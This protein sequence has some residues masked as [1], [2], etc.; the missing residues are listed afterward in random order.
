MNKW[1]PADIAFLEVIPVAEGAHACLDANN[2]T[3]DYFF[4]DF[5]DAWLSRTSSQVDLTKFHPKASAHLLPV[6]LEHTEFREFC[7]TPDRHNSTTVHFSSATFYQNR[8]G[9]RFRFRFVANRFLR[10][11]V[12]ILVNDLLMIGRNEMSPH[13][14]HA[15]LKTRSRQGPVRTA[16]PEGLYLTGVSYPYIDRPPQLPLCGQGEWEAIS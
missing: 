5:P 6:L 3:Y 11:M 15:L 13:Q 14:F 9:S 4:H 8:D 12:R 10:G 2:R 7:L 1:L 16:P